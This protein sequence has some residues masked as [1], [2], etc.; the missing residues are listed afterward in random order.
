[1][2]LRAPIKAHQPI[3]GLV[4][5]N[6]ARP[7]RPIARNRLDTQNRTQKAGLHALLAIPHSHL[8]YESRGSTLIFKWRVKSVGGRDS[9]A[10]RPRDV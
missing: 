8:L 3:G 5:R 4:S 9:R 7:R 6:E 10:A 1:M 2:L